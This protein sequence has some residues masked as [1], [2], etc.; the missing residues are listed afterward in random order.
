V[1]S[2]SEIDEVLD[3]SDRILVVSRGRLVGELPAGA[4][5]HDVLDLSFSATSATPALPG[6]KEAQ[7]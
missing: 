4:T 7:S 5:A 2:S 6:P 1:W 3:H